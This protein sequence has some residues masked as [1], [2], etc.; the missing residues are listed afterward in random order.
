MKPSI[1][2]L[3]RI[4]WNF[5][6]YKSDFYPADLGTLH[7][8]PAAFVPQIPHLLIETL[9]EPNNIVLDPFVGSGITIIEAARLQ[10][11]FIGIDC[12]PHAVKISIAKI[13]VLSLKNRNWY[14]NEIA[15]VQGIEFS[16]NAIKYINSNAI[17]SE[18]FEWFEE[19]TFNE[20]LGL[21][22]HIH[23]Y[24]GFHDNIIREIIFSSI[25]NKCCSQREHYTYITDGCIPSKKTYRPAKQ[26]YIDQLLYINDAVL[27]TK[28]HFK[29]LNDMDWDPS[30]MGQIF[31]SDSRSL[32][33]LRDSSIDL[34]VTSPPY[35]GVNDYARSMRLSHLFFPDQK[36]ENAIADE[37]GARRKRNRKFAFEEYESDMEKCFREVAR[38]LKEGCYLGLVMG[39]GR[40]KVNKSDII[41]RQL[42]LLEEELCFELVFKEQRQ[43]KFRR[44]QVPGVDKE[45]IL[46]FKKKKES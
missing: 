42:K 2:A 32:N 8:Y 5:S 36:I 37:I 13:K 11:R 15:K 34:I 16:K 23:N 28:K 22:E 4:D 20:L 38:V 17:S 10:R 33:F 30:N 44:I 21:H 31:L 25:L 12:N 7:W 18:I 46:I 27:L 24:K 3:S 41:E 1:N 9:S 43:I 45:R 29:R 39:Q 19:K 35:L 40:G 26:L 14:K 6:D